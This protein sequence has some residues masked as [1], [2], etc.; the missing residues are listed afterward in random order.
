MVS[1]LRTRTASVLAVLGLLLLAPAGHTSAAPAR[2]SIDKVT[3]HYDERDNEYL[4]VWWHESGDDPFEMKSC[5]ANAGTY[6][7]ESCTGDCWLDAFSTGNNR[8]EF[9]SDGRWQPSTPVEK[10]TYYTFPNHPGGVDFRAI[11][12]E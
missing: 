4:Q 3:C 9:L 7:W 5:F 2:P 1:P 12:I 8:V 6:E 10:N 11:W